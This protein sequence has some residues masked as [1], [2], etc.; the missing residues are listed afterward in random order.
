MVRLCQTL[1]SSRS[2][3]HLPLALQIKVGLEEWGGASPTETGGGVTER[4]QM[5]AEAV[6]EIERVGDAKSGMGRSSSRRRH[7]EGEDKGGRPAQHA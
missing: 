5:P 2:A 1:R 3:A 4:W 6:V 7:K